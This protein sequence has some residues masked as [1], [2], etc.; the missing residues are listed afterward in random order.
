MTP[1][2]LAITLHSDQTIPNLIN[3][4]LEQVLAS[5]RGADVHVGPSIHAEW[6]RPTFR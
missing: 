6:G 2:V 1:L 3:G 5:R 4:G